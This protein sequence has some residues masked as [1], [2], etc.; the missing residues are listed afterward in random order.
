LLLPQILGLGLA[1]AALLLLS[2]W[3][4]RLVQVV[5]LRLTGIERFALT[6]YF[7][8][9]LPGIVL[10]ELSHALVAKLLG[11]RVGKFSLGLRWRGKSVELGSV[12]VSSGG[13]IRDSLVGLAPLVSGTAVL[14]LVGSQVFDIPALGEAWARA[15][16]SGVF[17]RVDG[18]GSVPDFWLWAYVIFVVSNAM[19]PSAADRQPWLVAGLYLTLAVALAYLLVGLPIL[20][21]ALS[22]KVAGAL[23][24]LTLSFLFTLFV[25]LLAAMVLWFVEGL[26]I[27]VKGQ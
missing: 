15:G 2:R 11:M 8:L 14:L 7:L 27:Q 9:M 4:T 17:Q 20:P 16:W 22:A 10:H 21:D 6:V 24:L 23:Q 13:V 12:T 1:L 3:I 19:T 25:D 18:L 5:G 26:I